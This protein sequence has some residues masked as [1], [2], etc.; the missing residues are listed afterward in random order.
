MESDDKM[1]VMIVFIL[2]GLLGT[3][4]VHC[5]RQTTKRSA[6]LAGVQEACLKAGNAV[7]ECKE[8]R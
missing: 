2:A 6:L 4:T 7:L 8:L 1:A 5:D 3:V